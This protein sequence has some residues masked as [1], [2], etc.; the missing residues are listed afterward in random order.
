[1]RLPLQK[2]INLRNSGKH[3]KQTR[4][5]DYALLKRCWLMPVVVTV[6]GVGPVP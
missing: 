5:E 2:K 4:R 6:V 1:M 3:H